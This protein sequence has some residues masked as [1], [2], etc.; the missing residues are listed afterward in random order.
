MN[1]KGRKSSSYLVHKGRGGRGTAVLGL[2]ER[3]WSG[4]GGKK[5]RDMDKGMEKKSVQ[6]YV[7]LILTCDVYKS[8]MVLGTII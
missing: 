5:E 7:G 6:G 1:K 8:Y 2:N 3:G 4:E